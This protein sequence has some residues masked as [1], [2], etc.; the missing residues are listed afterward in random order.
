MEW[1]PIFQ[2]F[3]EK[4]PYSHTIRCHYALIVHLAHA[5]AW[6]ALRCSPVD[7]RPWCTLDG[8]S[9]QELSTEAL[10]KS[11]DTKTQPGQGLEICSLWAH[12]GT[13]KCRSR[14]YILLYLVF[15]PIPF[16]WIEPWSG[17]NSK[18]ELEFCPHSDVWEKL[19]QAMNFLLKK[20]IVYTY[21][22]CPKWWCMLYGAFYSNFSIQPYMFD[23][24]NIQQ[25]TRTQTH[26]RCPCNCSCGFV[27]PELGIED[28]K[29]QFWGRWPSSYVRGSRAQ[30]RIQHSQ[31][32]S[33]KQVL[34][35]YKLHIC[36]FNMSRFKHHRFGQMKAALN[37]NRT[38]REYDIKNI[39]N[40]CI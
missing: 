11:A 39:Q 36:L 33:P 23:V 40:I 27:A 4:N 16:P 1:I 3:P 14:S 19:W 7:A 28:P 34:V 18:N 12:N 2:C 24:K 17:T 32:P 22:C 25:G 38:I 8:K 37:H 9:C 15:L 10:Q 30:R 6:A 21:T 29:K 35:H 13:Y 5:I 31:T 20:Y 26:L